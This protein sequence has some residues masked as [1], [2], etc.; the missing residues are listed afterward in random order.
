M[1]ANLNGRLIKLEDGELYW[2]RHISRSG[3]MKNPYWVKYEQT[4]VTDIRGNQY[5]KINAGRHFFIHRVIYYIHNQEW[6]IWDGSKSNL[7]DHIDR[8]TFN[9]NIENLRVVT[10]QQNCCNKGTTNVT[11]TKYNTYRAKV[12]FGDIHISKCY[13]T[14]QEAINAV[15]EFKLKYHQ[16]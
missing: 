4:I 13:K 14:E 3:E 9:N 6:D 12:S 10:N 8:N 15:A 5:K 16:F 11:I 2:W 7:I 1:E